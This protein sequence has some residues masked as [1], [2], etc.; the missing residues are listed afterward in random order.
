M[1][2][3]YRGNAFVQASRNFF[4]HG[5]GTPGVNAGSIELFINRLQIT[6]R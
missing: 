1:I 6:A 5:L 4:T 2:R 3:R